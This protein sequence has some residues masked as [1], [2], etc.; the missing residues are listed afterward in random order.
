MIDVEFGRGPSRGRQMKKLMLAGFSGLALMVAGSANAADMAVPAYKAPPPAAPAY[1][2]TGCYLG[3]QAGGGTMRDTYADVQGEGAIAGGQVGCNYQTGVLVFGVEGEGFWSGLTSVYRSSFPSDTP[4]YSNEYWAKN[5][6]DFD[7]AGRVGFAFDRALIYGKAGWDWG[8]FS[9]GY[10]D[11]T[12]GIVNG[13]RA[14]LDGLLIGVGLE[15][16]ITQ[17]LSAKF[18][19]D[20]MNFGA[21]SVSFPYFCPTC[22]TTNASYTASRSAEKQIFKLGL[23]Y[24]Y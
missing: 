17:N 22:F 20:N 19:Y 3:V 6:A 5:K 15:Y 16:G 14:T 12:G 13:A 8:L 4:P 21:K 24:R 10:T 11:S 23:N 1:I 2:W 18:E 7:V 9:W